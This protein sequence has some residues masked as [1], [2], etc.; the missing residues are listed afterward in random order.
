MGLLQ[1]KVAI[2]TGAGRGI[3]KA[4]A[5]LLAHAGAR[6]VVNDVGCAHDGTGRDPRV[7]AD[8]ADG[9]VAD[10]GV[11]VAN[12]QSV[13][14]P[15][16]ARAI[17]ECALDEYGAVDVLVNNAGI[18]HNE[19]LLDMSP[20]VWD[21][22]NDVHL[23]AAF[24]CTQ[25]AARHMLTRGGGRIVNTVSRAGLLGSLDQANCAAA[26]AGVYGLTRTAAIEL[27]RHRIAV[28]AVAPLARTRLTDHL[29]ALDGMDMLTAD[30]VA[31]ATL[32]LASDLCA[33]LTGCVL[34]VAG[35]R[36][37]VFRMVESR[38]Q[39]KEGHRGIWRAEEIAEHW[40]AI[41]KV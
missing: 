9:I 23:R 16:G 30:H 34:A 38:G 4:T 6:V 17:V 2:V 39:F 22:V 40:E 19:A 3:G 11:A 41:S 14:S 10:G 31:P 7:A 36:L 20:E 24:L 37:S 32:F 18:L 27:Q 33:D 35:G 1:D 28:N 25:A 26:H 29:E 12:T 13:A 8:V 5:R 21:T 15:Q